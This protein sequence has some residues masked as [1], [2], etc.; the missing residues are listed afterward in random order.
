M[1]D[2][3]NVRTDQEAAC[4]YELAYEFVDWL[5]ARYPEDIAEIDSYLLHQKFDEQIRDVLI[6]YAPPKGECLL[7]RLN[8]D[9]VGILMLKDL[10]QKTC[11]VNRMFVRPKGR[12]Q[13]IGRALMA[14][15]MTR[16]RE[17]GFDYMVLGAL[18]R[19][20]EALA[21][22]RSVGFKPDT[23]T[24]GS[25]EPDNAIHLRLDLNA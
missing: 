1:L 25:G 16:A 13:G 9:P 11:E 23:A 20:D 17:M 6:H 19:H 21:L 5:K 22:Y 14:H 7:A 18:N 12:G 24:Q 15:L 3:N 10:G 2:I 8:G 4:V